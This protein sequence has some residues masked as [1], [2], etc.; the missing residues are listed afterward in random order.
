MNI[1]DDERKA[2]EDLL[3]WRAAGTLSRGE[4][5]RVDAALA[6]D[7]ELARRYA[8]VREEVTQ[9][10]QLNEALGTPSPRALD[11]LFA[12][13]DAEPAR[14]PAP[15]R[16]NILDRIVE[17]FA[18]LSPRTLAFGTAAAALILTLQAGVIG[19]YVLRDK[20]SGGYE[21]ASEASK[22]LGA[23]SYV[24]IRFA[25][26]ANADAITQFL[27]SNKLTIANGPSAGGL[28]LVRATQTKIS[29]ADL[30]SLADRLQHDKAV[31]FIVPSE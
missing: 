12:K 15:A 19:N 25:P 6:A 22:P 4:T 21:T 11:A 1:A 28:Y 20:A 5:Q 16:P 23:G 3:P 27:Q 17:F 13:I 9:T 30:Q 18:S 29:P 10:I 2:I 8:I 14:R 24:L 31:G 7:P 26:Q